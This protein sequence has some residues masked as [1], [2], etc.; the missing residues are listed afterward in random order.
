MP[1]NQRGVNGKETTTP[2]IWQTSASLLRNT[3]TLATVLETNGVF[4]FR[5][6]SAE[7]GAQ[8]CDQR[9]NLQN[10]ASAHLC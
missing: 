7:T 10:P 6:A 1:E 8:D 2:Y 4:V 9:S 3:H 5:R